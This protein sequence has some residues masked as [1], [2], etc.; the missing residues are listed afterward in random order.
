MEILIRLDRFDTLPAVGTHRKRSEALFKSVEEIY[1]NCSSDSDAY[2]RDSIYD[3]DFVFGDEQPQEII[4]RAESWNAQLQ[5]DVRRALEN[6]EQIRRK[7]GGEYPMDSL[8]TYQARKA[9]LALDNRFYDYAECATCLG[10]EQDY[11]E[12]IIREE[13]LRDIQ[14]HP[15]RYALVAVYPK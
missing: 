8:D 2:L 1:N 14:I 6:L 11:F 4:Q 9:L 12:T 13:E 10:Q 15:E 7:N 5:E 3:D